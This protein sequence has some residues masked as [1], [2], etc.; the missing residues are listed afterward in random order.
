MATSRIVRRSVLLA[1]ACVLAGRATAAAPAPGDGYWVIRIAGHDVGYVHEASE[2]DPAD[3]A[4]V[5]DTELRMVLNRLGSKVAIS[6]DARTRESRALRL[7]EE[8]CVMSMSEQSTTLDATFGDGA[9]SLDSAVGD[10]HYHRELPLTSAPLGPQ[11]LRA[12]ARAQLGTA[13][14]QASYVVFLPELA[15][16]VDVTRRVEAEAAGLRIREEMTGLPASTLWLDADGGLVRQ[17]QTGALRRAADGA[18]R[19]NDRARGGL[20]RRASRGDV[21][22]HARARECAPGAGPGD[23]GRRAEDHATGHDTGLAALRGPGP[24][25]AAPVSDGNRAADHAD[26]GPDGADRAARARDRRQPRGP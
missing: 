13:G 7:L 15:A 3:G 12:L 23:R 1:L 10:Q 5:T 6:A 24:A 19:C 18:L 21:R 4:F 9:V 16:V 26:A 20:G 17:E 22:R 25:R 2:E 14:G 11:G 8:H